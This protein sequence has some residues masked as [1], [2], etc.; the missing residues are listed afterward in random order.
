M[1][2]LQL[3]WQCGGSGGLLCLLVVQ[4]LSGV[5]WVKLLPNAQHVQGVHV[6]LHTARAVYG[7]GESLAHSQGN[8][9]VSLT[10]AQNVW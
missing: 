4:Q 1:R 9:K 3:Q 2:G 8:N 5:D 7:H 10:T 6:S